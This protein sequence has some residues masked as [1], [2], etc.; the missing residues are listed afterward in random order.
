MN[1][2]S[3]FDLVLT[4]M[5]DKNSKNF[6][7]ELN[8][9]ITAQNNYFRKLDLNQRIK[10][11]SETGISSI[12][13]QDYKSFDQLRKGILLFPPEKKVLF[14]D[15]ELLILVL[16]RC[17][18]IYS[19]ELNKNKT[20]D[21]SKDDFV[22]F[23]NKIDEYINSFKYEEILSKPDFFLEFS[24][25]NIQ[26]YI[27]K[28]PPPELMHFSQND[29]VLKINMDKDIC[30]LKKISG[31]VLDDFYQKKKFYDLC[32]EFISSN[33]IFVDSKQKLLFEYQYL[34]NNFFNNFIA[35]YIEK[36][37]LDKDSI[38]FIYKGG[39]FMKI[40]YEK[41][42]DI[43]KSN[44]N[45]MKQNSNYFKRSDSDYGLF[46][47]YK[48]DR[49]EYTKHYYW[50][51]VLTYNILTH[52]SK[53]IDSNIQSI[54]P[55]NEI[56]DNDLKSQLEKVNKM[57]S[58]DRDRIN[59][60]K[61]K[62]LTYFDGIEEFI[63]I[64]IGNKTYMKEQIPEKFNF[65]ILKSTSMTDGTTF[66]HKNEYIDKSE[67]MKK[68]RYIPIQRNPF[69][70]TIKEEGEKYYQAL[71]NIDEKP[72]DSGVYQYYNETNRFARH[73]GTEI[74]Y[75]TLHRVKLNIILYFKTWSKNDTNVSYGFF[76]C[77]SELIDVPIS[78]F[79]DYKKN[80]DFDKNLQEYENI[81]D[82][83]NLIFYSYNIY[84]IVDDICKAIFVDSI[85][86]WD[87]IK[88][89]KKIHRLVYFFLIYLNNAYSNWDEIKNKLENYFNTY[90][91]EDAQLNFKTYNDNE[92]LED[93]LYN[94]ILNYL[95]EVNKRVE[96]SGNKD[97]KDK[98]VSIKNIFISNLDIF[99][100]EKIP[101]DISE[102]GLVFVPYLKKY[103]K[104]KQKYLEI[105]NK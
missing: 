21:E 17:N 43:M 94:K 71:C 59:V 85:Y 74:T 63:G 1:K 58:E 95:S 49:K 66:K 23:I 87:D 81:I 54:L 6:W 32:T 8:E 52:V 48:L 16:K 50:M 89:E 40:L 28:S 15:I 90:N 5:K 101:D 31:E 80:L 64:S 56:T 29:K 42:N 91:I 33:K 46:I 75:F 2:Y 24:D 105:K 27:N 35:K 55:I 93:S 12:K 10:L 57:L 79:D 100:Q 22:V 76:Q 41:Y 83:K 61:Q 72:L 30:S 51:N 20:S 18:T 99:N 25:S 69:Y 86:P 78:T 26:E 97:Y 103:L 92:I 14:D 37:G 53:F 98:M 60:K 62:T 67:F 47:N 73:V 19:F 11:A 65:K 9:V 7:N 44:Q 104:Y 70:I 84:G 77:P 39:T 38:L 45:F 82:G 68:N 34:I 4:F 36:N 88:F 102:T 3:Y 96:K 13:E